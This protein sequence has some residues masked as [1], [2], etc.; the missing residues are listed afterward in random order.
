MDG[1]NVLVRVASERLVEGSPGGLLGNADRAANG[2]ERMMAQPKGDNLLFALSDI[3]LG[4]G[5]TFV[6][7]RTALRRFI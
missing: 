1:L 6:A 2:G 5:C 4:L 7:A 3:F